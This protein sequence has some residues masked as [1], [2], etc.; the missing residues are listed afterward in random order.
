MN[1]AFPVPA[2][3]LNSEPQNHNT[4]MKRQIL[5]SKPLIH[6]AIA[7]LTAAVTS[8]ASAATEAFGDLNHDGLIDVAAIT[9]PTTVTIYL[10]NPDG[11]YTVSAI[12]PVPKKQKIT[13][14][15]LY[16][17]DGD[18]D[19]D[20]AASGAVSGNWFYTHA[21]SGNGDGTFGA[22]TTSRWSFP[23]GGW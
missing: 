3:Q 11:S 2:L 1:P 5:I 12:L 13:H 17:H 9:S 16:D 18:G 21:W 23:H 22:R 10:A 4:T 14:V 8:S 20:V 7:L 6:A 19:L 15:D